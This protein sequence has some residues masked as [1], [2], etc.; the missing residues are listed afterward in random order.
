[1]VREQLENM[2]QFSKMSVN[3][4]IDLYEVALLANFPVV[5]CPLQHQFLPGVYIRTIFM[6]A[7][8]RITSL[9]HRT[10]HQYIILK[11]KVNVFTEE[12]GIVTLA[13]P[14][15][16]ITQPGTRRVLEILE[17]CVWLTIHPTTIVPENDSEEAI[18]AAVE[19]VKEQIIEP[20][21]NLLISEIKDQLNLVNG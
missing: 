2:E 11:G 18:L 12:D 9:V 19:K 5:E 7:G 6:S 4:Q 1:M 21:E 16:G 13:A 10:R 20:Y 15:V 14:Y 17:D 8:N 3:E